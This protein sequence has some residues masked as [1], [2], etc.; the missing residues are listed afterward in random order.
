MLSCFQSYWENEVQDQCT[1]N[2][3]LLQASSNGC[4]LV[5]W[6]HLQICALIC[7]WDMGKCKTCHEWNSN[8]SENWCFWKLINC[9][10]KTFIAKLHWNQASN[11]LALADAVDPH[12]SGHLESLILIWDRLN[13]KSHKIIHVDMTCQRS[14]SARLTMAHSNCSYFSSS[15]ICPCFQQVL[16]L[17]VI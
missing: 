16:S 7:S 1:K 14:Y 12:S 4:L 9:P 15:C 3:T 6:C 13:K 2:K 8:S 11:F 17:L 10:Y 5:R